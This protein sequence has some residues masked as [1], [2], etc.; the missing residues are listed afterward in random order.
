MICGEGVDVGSVLQWLAFVVGVL[1][2]FSLWTFL[3]QLV[4]QQ[5]RILVRLDRLDER[6]PPGEIPPGAA[7]GQRLFPPGISVGDT[8]PSFRLPDV[9]GEMLALEDLRGKRVVLVHWGTQCG[10]C[11]QVAPE[12]VRLE[13]DLRRRKSEL[14]LVSSGEVEQNRRYAAEHGLRFRTVLQPRGEPIE[15]FRMLG[16][17][18]AYL[19]D[20]RGK[21]AAPVAIGANAVPA[22][23][24]EAAAGTKRLPGQRALSE[25]KIER[26]GLKAGTQAPE[27]ELPTLDGQPLSLR[28]YRGRRLL[29]VFSDPHCGP[30]DAL[31]PELARLHREQRGDELAL[32]M[33]TRGD[34]EENRRK[35]EQYGLDFPLVIQPGWKVSK[36][37]GI[38]ATPVAFLIDHDG[39]IERNV[40]NGKDEILA[41]AREGL[42]AGMGAPVG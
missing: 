32:L 14:L 29:L 18:V 30:C 42:R 28:E 40:A 41:R 22:L 20:E 7:D 34:P 2:L 27:F 25:S 1:T 9:G 17:P 12:L 4:R 6:L 37:Y 5:G 35:A 15:A 16:T 21:V 33:V 8:F 23:V 3:Y 36:Q 38:F 19:L 24:R 31:S 13:D 10:F 26:E 39:V 11:D